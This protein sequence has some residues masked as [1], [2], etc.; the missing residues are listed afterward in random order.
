[1]CKRIGDLQDKVGELFT[2]LPPAFQHSQY[3]RLGDVHSAFNSLQIDALRIE[4]EM[5][6]LKKAERELS[7]Y[8][9]KEW[10]DKVWNAYKLSMYGGDAVVEPTEAEASIGRIN[11]KNRLAN[12]SIE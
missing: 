9:L 12:D 1:M 8:K 3:H 2:H 5:R 6:E 10:G 7:R 11:S 4:S